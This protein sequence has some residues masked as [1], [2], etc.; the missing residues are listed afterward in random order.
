[1]KKILAHLILLPLVFLAGCMSPPAGLDLSSQRLSANRTYI[2]ESHPMDGHAPINKMHAWEVR[3]TLPSG[4]PVD[5][6]RIAVDGGMPQHGHG[7]PTQPK[8]TRALGDGRYL[9]EGV[10]FSMPGWW[11]LKLKIDG[12]QGRDDVTFNTVVSL[13]APHHTNAPDLVA[14][15]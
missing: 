14:R 11:E 10:K 5:G 9:V 4:Q 6:A 7:L 2:V 1:M 13:M 3:V 12:A 8:V 15:R